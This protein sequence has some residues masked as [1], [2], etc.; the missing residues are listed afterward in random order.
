M[1]RRKG[2]ISDERRKKRMEKLLA[3]LRENVPGEHLDAKESFFM[4][5]EG[6]DREREKLEREERNAEEALAHA[7]DF[8]EKAF[9]DGEEMV[10]FVTELT[11]SAGSAVSLRSIHRKNMNSI[12]KHF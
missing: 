3:C 5:K 12:R 8:M 1:R 9:E 11:V 2:R 6:F 4:A 10:L 7:F